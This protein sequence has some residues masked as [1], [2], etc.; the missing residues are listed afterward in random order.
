MA[1]EPGGYADK[2]GNRYEGRWVVLQLLRVL[3][4][5]LRSVTCER[6]GE[7][8]DGVDLSVEYANGVRR[9]QQCKIRNRGKNDWSIADLHQRGILTAMRRHLDLGPINQFALVTPLPSIFLHDISES[10]RNSSGDPEDF[11]NYQIE[12]VGEDRRKGFRQFCKHLGLDSD[13]QGNRAQAFSYLQRLFIETWPDTTGSRE[14]LVGRA[15]M[16]VRV[17]PDGEPSTIVAVLADFAQD[18]LRKRLDAATIWS[19]LESRGFRPRQLPHDTRI[20]PRIQ[21]LQTQF[22]E[23]ISGDLI[24]GKLIDRSETQKILESVRHNDVIVLHGSPGQGKSGVL[25]G[26]AEEFKRLDVAYLP[27]RLDRQEP[28]KTSRQYGTDLG[29]PESPVK[30]LEA[31]AADRPAVLVLDQLDAIR[32]T[33]RHS[34]GALEVCKELV[35]EIKYLRATGKQVSVVLACRTYD[36]QNDPDIKNWLQSEKR[37]DGG[38]VEINVEPLSAESVAGVVTF[39]GQNPSQMPDR[40]RNILQSPQHLA[41]WVRI[42]Q[43]RGAFEFQSRVQL[44]REY[45][46]GRMREMGRWGVSESDA[47]R[48]LASLVEYMEHKGCITA[49][50]SLMAD[51]TILDALCSCGLIRASDGQIAFAHQTY[52]DYQIASRVVREIHANNQ[53]V[54]AWLG[55]RDRQSLRRREPLRQ[56]LCLLGEESADDFRA[57]IRSILTSDNVRFHL[58]HLCLEVIGQLDN[59]PES[60]LAYLKGIVAT[61]EWKEHVLGTV[62]LRHPP[63]VKLL[64]EDGTISRWLEMDEWRNAALWMLRNIAEVMPDSV[65]EILA[66]Y[67]RRDGEWK[68]RVLGCLSWNPEDDSGSM[69]EL[70]LELARQGEFREYVDWDKLPGHRSLQLLEAVLTYWEPADLPQDYLGR[71]RNRRLRFENWSDRDL[72]HFVRVVRDMPEQAWAMLMPHICRLAPQSGEPTRPLELWMDGDNHGIRQGIECVP[73]GLVQLAVEAGKCLANQDGRAFWQR[74]EPLRSHGS[75]IVQYVLIET[76]SALPAQV[77]DEALGWLLADSKRLCIGT[78]NYAPEWKP[79]ARL[80]EALSPVC[81]MSLFRQLEQALIHYHSP[82]E[83]QDA[84]YWVSGWKQGYYGDYW[85]RAQHFLLPSLCATRRNDMANGLIGVLERK[86]AGYSEDRFVRS[87]GSFGHI[88]S[89]L[90]TKGSSR[91]SDTAWLAIVRNQRIPEDTHDRRHRKGGH[92]E[93]SSIRMFSRDLQQVAK[94]FPTRFGRLA[95]RFPDDVHSSYRAAILDGLQQTEPRD[96]PDDEKAA[97]EPAPVA[98]VEQVLARFAGTSGRDYASSFCWL[99]YHRAEER[100]SD[101]AYRQLVEYACGH[102][103]PEDG[104]LCVGNKNGGF[105]SAEATVENLENN[106][107]NCVRGVAALAIGQQL[108]NHSDLL[109]QFRPAITQLCKDPHPAVRVA[110]VRACLPILNLDRDFAIECFCEASAND[111][112]VAASREGVD[113]F[114]CGMQ[115]QT[116][117]LAPL[118]T[119][120]LQAPQTDVVELGAQEVAARWLFHDYFATELENCL[121]GSIPERK[122]LAYVAAHFVA[123][124]KYLEKC[125]RLIERLKDDPENEVR[126]LLQ[127][128]VRS[129]DVLRLPEGVRLVRSFIESQAFRDDP[130]GLIYG[131]GDHSGSLLPFSDVLLSMCDQF[132][133]PLRDACRDSSQG[134][135]HDLSLFVP[136]LIRLYE[137]AEEAKND[138]VVSRCLDAWDAMFE[139]RVGVIHE[140]AQAIG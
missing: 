93:E 92:W 103:D 84:E 5:D 27:L 130:T 119:R 55:Q 50:R 32:W 140:L 25:L 118:V 139:G 131:L 56:A 72:A 75:P 67:A 2:L 132:V 36:M 117:R 14:D 83:R 61:D 31:V 125:S 44:V 1:L 52:L 28:Q 79:A 109:D 62:F 128:M 45:W 97:W 120:M 38:L 102:P 134:V 11:F 21:T 81:S 73:Y 121:Q 129:T 12:A 89:T 136:I 47:N 54:C 59:P 18:N 71:D 33:S 8:Q 37:K 9:D 80:I 7:D 40:Q 137:Q 23:S 6:V 87:H 111:L 10:A 49:P 48:A 124:P 74:T 90:A 100:W 4:E 104:K 77:A 63:F 106:A 95:L 66:P 22:A 39:L 69:F 113:F 91:I 35:R 110:A 85:G 112:R 88:G 42:T 30:C 15:G 123:N 114:N 57:A 127:S 68:K 13:S 19:Y 138:Q 116:E 133:G 96:V 76:Y 3:N 105:D 16:L 64:I 135:L 24:A 51:T 26:L 34:L 126:Q 20:A 107:L 108:W 29:L 78:G 43:E 53:D 122:G 41:M 94:R 70:R 58:K 115:S 82:D 86:F 60:L 99:L 101:A 98:L 46:N 17:K 65:V